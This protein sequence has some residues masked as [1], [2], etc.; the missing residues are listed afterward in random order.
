MFFAG[1]SQVE[2]LGKVWTPSVL[3]CRWLQK[4]FVWPYTKWA[5]LV[6]KKRRSARVDRSNGDAAVVLRVCLFL[7]MVCG[8]CGGGWRGGDRSLEKFVGSNDHICFFFPERE[9]AEVRWSSRSSSL[10][11]RL[12]MKEMEGLITRITRQKGKVVLVASGGTL[13]HILKH[14]QIRDNIYSPYKVRIFT[15]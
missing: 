11:R 15:K 6:E 13:A 9:E 10:K 8:A 1:D 7:R 4:S 5:G 12:R 3:P 14:T 2:S